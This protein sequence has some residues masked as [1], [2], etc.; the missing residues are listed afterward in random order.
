[1]FGA[2]PNVQHLRPFGC[3]ALKFVDKV[4]RATKLSKRGTST[5]MIGYATKT[6]GYRLLDVESELITEHRRQNV[7]FYEQTTVAT[8][9]VKKLLNVVYRHRSRPNVDCS[10]LPFVSFPVSELPA[11]RETSSEKKSSSEDAYSQPYRD[12]PNTEEMKEESLEEKKPIPMRKRHLPV[13][14]KEPRQSK[15]ERRRS[16]RLKDFVASIFTTSTSATAAMGLH[17]PLTWDEM[18]ASPQCAQWL[19]ATKDEFLPQLKNETWILVHRPKGAHILKN[20][21]IWILKENEHRLIRFKARLVIVG[22]LQI[23]GLEFDD[24]L[25]RLCVLR[26]YGLRCCTRD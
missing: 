14:L 5:L 17:V 3:F 10:K 20:K 15:R 7:K 22:C 4:Y 12:I 9:N 26:R 16:E 23:W 1:M 2:K 25:L 8:E 6:K 19:E 24:I 13:E 21:W 11:A 18:M